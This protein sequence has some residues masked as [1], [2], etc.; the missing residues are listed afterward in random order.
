MC[1]TATRSR[2][3]GETLD[4]GQHYCHGQDMT[5]TSIVVN[6]VAFIA[7]VFFTLHS[8]AVL[9]LI[10]PYQTREVQNGAS[11]RNEQAP[12]TTPKPQDSTGTTTTSS[13][14]MM[15]KRLLAVFLL[16]LC[17]VCATAAPTTQSP[18]ATLASPAIRNQGNTTNAQKDNPQ[19]PKP[20]VGALDR[21]IFI[22]IVSCAAVLLLWVCCCFCCFC[23]K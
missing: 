3:I 16:A 6:C 20:K 17:L 18:P 19:K 10:I 8:C 2:L 5:D 7:I 11:L 4:L 23:C 13:I 22:V 1:C 14:V 12:A 9:P 21:N 15:P